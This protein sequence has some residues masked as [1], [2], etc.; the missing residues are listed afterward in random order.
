MNINNKTLKSI[1]IAQND[2]IRYMTGLSRNSHISNTLKILTIF[3][4]Y[5]LYTYMKLIF[6]KN[7]RSNKICSSIFNY[8][9][10]S[11]YKKTTLSFIRDFNTICSKLNLDS[12]FVI[13]NIVSII[14]TYKKDTLAYEDSIDNDLITVCQ[15]N[16]TDPI[17]RFQLNQVTHV[18]LKF[19]F[20]Y[21]NCIFLFTFIFLIFYL[22]YFSY[23]LFNCNIN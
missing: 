7:L 17:M 12:S 22:L 5:E 19:S 16:N 2:I 15:Q 14:C 23:I 1:N 3:K 6:V 13:N 20:I 9:L 8:L 11:N 18:N 10:S 21:S 4:I